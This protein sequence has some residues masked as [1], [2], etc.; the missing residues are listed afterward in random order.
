[1]PLL[2]GI[3]QQLIEAG[4][5]PLLIFSAQTCA[6]DGDQPCD[7]SVFGLADFLGC[8][9][10]RAR[11]PQPIAHRMLG[12]VGSPYLIRKGS[13]HETRFL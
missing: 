11:F 5:L 9:E 10:S 4:L 3:T 8:R 12:I 7:S 6:I 13:L 2:A 1:M